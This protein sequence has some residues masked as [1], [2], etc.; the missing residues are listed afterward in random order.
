VHRLRAGEL[1]I[2]PTDTVYG[3]ACVADLRPAVERLYALK[4][5]LASQPTAIM[6]GSVEHLLSDV[7]PEAR[8]RAGAILQAVLPGTV[9]LIV[10][11]PARRFPAVCGD[12]PEAIGVRVPVLQSDVAA[13]A[14][15]V[16]GVVISSA[17]AR[18]EPAP[19]RV[20]DVPE[21]LRR[22]CGVVVDAGVLP[23]T[24][25]AVIDVCGAEPLIVRDAPGSERLV[26]LIHAS[27]R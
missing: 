9:T 11:N 23:G 3:I 18:G 21:Q 22:A 10:P 4:H 5:R 13:L 17:N 25:S 16:G 2:L 8:E 19:A 24:P 20:E 15:A 14:D 12:T 27:A 7:L 1:A 26:A 6:C